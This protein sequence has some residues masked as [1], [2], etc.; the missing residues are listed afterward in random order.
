MRC[1]DAERRAIKYET[2]KTDGAIQYC[3][4]YKMACTDSAVLNSHFKIKAD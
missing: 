1:F 2:S 3:R 4:I